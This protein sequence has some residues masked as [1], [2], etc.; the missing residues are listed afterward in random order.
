MKLLIIISAAELSEKWCDNIKILNNYMQNN[1]MEIEYC[2]ISNQDDFHNY[3]TIIQFKYKIINTKLQFSK[4]CDFITE[5]KS[6]LDYDW[7]MKIRPDMQL[8]DNIVFDML[9]ENAI[10]ARARTYYGPKKIK[11]GM[12]VNGEGIWKDI[13]DC[14]YADTESNVILDDQVYI[15]HKNTIQNNAFEKNTILYE[16]ENEWIYTNVF[17]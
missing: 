5:Y 10:N 2:G 16:Y 7:Y 13:G 4:I 12:A 1:N 14:Y 17:N 3:E 11:Y 15:F 6:Q 9:S 8:L